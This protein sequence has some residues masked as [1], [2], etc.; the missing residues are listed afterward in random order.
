MMLATRIGHIHRGI[1]IHFFLKDVAVYMAKVDAF[2]LLTLKR[3][4]SSMSKDLCQIRVLTV[5]YVI[6]L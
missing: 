6:I 5:F 1:P 3:F 4:Y 2:R